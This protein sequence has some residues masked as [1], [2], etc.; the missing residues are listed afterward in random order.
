VITSSAKVINAERLLKKM[1]IIPEAMRGGIRKVM[2]E[3]A[4]E[5]VA[6]MKRLVPVSPGG[7]DLKNSIGW[8]WGLA[9]PASEKTVAKIQAGG[10]ASEDLTITIYA[11][12][13]EAYYARWVEFGTRKMA[14]RP[15]FFVSWRASRKMIRRKVQAEIRSV[16]K[17][18]AAGASAKTAA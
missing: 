3:H 6:M 1:T 16:A 9:G 12:N 18:V 17:A 5:V 10:R 7:G 15:F 11:G 13:A 4:D 8:R 2:A 14:K